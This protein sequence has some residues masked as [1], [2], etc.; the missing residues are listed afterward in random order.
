L[1]VEHFAFGEITAASGTAFLVSKMDGILGLGFRTISI[2]DDPMFIE[3]AATD[4]HSF[5][6]KMG[7][8][9]K[10]EESYMVVPGYLEEDLASEMVYHEV[11]EKMYWSL[12]MTHVHRGDEEIVFESYPKFVVDSGT[13]LIMGD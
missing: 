1:T 3:E 8:I 9:N 7:D 11:I 4:D 5:S 13:S 6:F 2:N 10:D 12:N